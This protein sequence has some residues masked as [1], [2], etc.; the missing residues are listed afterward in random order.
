MYIYLMLAALSSPRMDIEV[1][2]K[3]C[4]IKEIIYDGIHTYVHAIGNCD[5][6]YELCLRDSCGVEKVPQKEL[7]FGKKDN[8][9]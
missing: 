5:V 1:L 8:I 9:G 6:I 7:N 4:Y 3:N 2:E